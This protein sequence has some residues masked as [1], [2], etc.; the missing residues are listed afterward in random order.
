MAT[1][2]TTGKVPTPRRVSASLSYAGHT[3][4]KRDRHE[5]APRMTEGYKVTGLPTGMVRVEHVVWDHT[6][7]RAKIDTALKKY[8]TTLTGAGYQVA[9]EDGV[10][11]VT[12][13]TET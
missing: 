13:K 11:Y 7:Y 3:V 6:G 2:S 10:L 4:S 12:A 5:P 9:A 8:T 1:T